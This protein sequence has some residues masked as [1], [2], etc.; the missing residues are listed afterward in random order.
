MCYNNIYLSEHVFG[1][2]WSDGEVDY[3]EL[4]SII[5][6]YTA[7]SLSLFTFG[8]ARQNFLQ[9]LIQKTIINLEDLNCPKYNSL[10]FPSR[11]CAF[12]L[13]KYSNFRCAVKEAWLYSNFLKYQDLASYVLPE[14][15]NLYNPTPITESDVH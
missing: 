5:A 2:D 14:N 12:P 13:H 1:F 11:T 7:S 8:S 10:A 15:R 4:K 6:T 9:D 3:K